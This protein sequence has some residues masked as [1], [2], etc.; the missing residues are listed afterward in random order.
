MSNNIQDA[1]NA[2][3]WADFIKWAAKSP[4]YVALYNAETGSNYNPFEQLS[5]I[6]AAIDK[7]TGFAE[8]SAFAFAR[9]VTEH[10]WGMEYAPAAFREDCQRRDAEK[11]EVKE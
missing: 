9:W 1:I 10:D 6:E 8:E 7:A 2:V 11:A 5:P 4:E 3:A